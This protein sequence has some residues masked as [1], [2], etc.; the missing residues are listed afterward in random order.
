[1]GNRAIGNRVSRGMTVLELKVKS[2]YKWNLGGP[3]GGFFKFAI[4]RASR[5]SLL[6]GG[7]TSTQ[8]SFFS[9]FSLLHTNV[10][11]VYENIEFIFSIMNFY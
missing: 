7:A 2:K 3:W 6:Q 10:K 1:M 11:K 8:P 5:Y 4:K 9:Y